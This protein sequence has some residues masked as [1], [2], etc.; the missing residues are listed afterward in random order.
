VKVQHWASAVLPRYRG[1]WQE[2]K[3]DLGSNEV[4]YS[5]VR[6]VAVRKYA[7]SG[8]AVLNNGPRKF[9]TPS[10]LAR[11]PGLFGSLHR[12]AVR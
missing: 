7:A 8:T 1:T 4:L 5:M 3:A 12:A 10:I 6:C 2:Q 11:V 9:A